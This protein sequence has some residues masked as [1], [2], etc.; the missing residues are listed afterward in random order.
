M[1]FP[2]SI[3]LLKVLNCLEFVKYFAEICTGSQMFITIVKSTL[4]Y[5]FISFLQNI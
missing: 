5:H 4:A 3:S 1:Y 2:I